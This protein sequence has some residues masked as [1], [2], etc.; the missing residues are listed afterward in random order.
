MS[1]GE[2]LELRSVKACNW[3]LFFTKVRWCYKS[4]NFFANITNKA[5]C[6]KIYHEYT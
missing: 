5:R 3:K 4:D 2:T 6:E 1:H